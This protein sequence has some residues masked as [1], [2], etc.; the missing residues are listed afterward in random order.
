MI[1]VGFIVSSTDFTFQVILKVKKV[2]S[3]QLLR[4][5]LF[6]TKPDNDQKTLNIYLY[7]RY[8]FYRAAWNADAV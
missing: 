5:C 1:H 4:C 3:G 6:L 7:E 2:T 8:N